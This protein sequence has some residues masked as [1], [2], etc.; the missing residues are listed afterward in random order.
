MVIRAG[1]WGRLFSIMGKN[2]TEVRWKFCVDGF[3]VDLHER[4][5]FRESKRG[6]KGRVYTSHRDFEL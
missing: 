6:Y 4:F 3:F 5:D 2:G 1:E